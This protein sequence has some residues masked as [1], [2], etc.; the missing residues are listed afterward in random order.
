[1]TERELRANALRLEHWRRLTEIPAL[2]WGALAESE[3]DRW[4]QEADEEVRDG[5]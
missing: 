2:P 5:A 3:R 4:L 1:M